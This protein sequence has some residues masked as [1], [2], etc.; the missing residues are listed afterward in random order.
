M[1]HQPTII[2]LLPEYTGNANVP[3]IEN[4]SR[5]G[6]LFYGANVANVPQAVETDS[7]S[8]PIKWKSLWATLF[9]LEGLARRCVNF[10]PLLVD[11][12]TQHIS[13]LR[14]QLLFIGNQQPLYAYGGYLPF[15]FTVRNRYGETP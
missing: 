5:R 10:H 12:L 6:Q 14:G 11:Q 7:C 2:G 1:V 8:L 4:D 13:L 15:L 9:Y 3:S